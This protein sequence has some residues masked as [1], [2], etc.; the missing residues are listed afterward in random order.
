[1]FA[2]NGQREINIDGVADNELELGSQIDS[3]CWGTS[4]LPMNQTNGLQANGVVGTAEYYRQLLM[5]SQS[6]QLQMM[7][8]T[9]QQCC[10]LLWAQQR[11]IQSLRNAM[12]Q[13]TLQ[14]RDSRPPE[15]EVNIFKF[16]IS[17]FIHF[18]FLKFYRDI[19]T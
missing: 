17:Q 12:N 3:N 13:L 18:L 11:E 6:Q 8:T 10:Q 9:I 2:V 7:C 4:S 1:M 15:A 14:L 19:Q 5:G 16:F